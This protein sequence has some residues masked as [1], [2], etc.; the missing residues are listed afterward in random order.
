MK[1]SIDCAPIAIEVTEQELIKASDAGESW[2][3][4]QQKIIEDLQSYAKK[5][6]SHPALTGLKMSKANETLL[7]RILSK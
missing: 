6:K 2:L 4:F 3:L 1:I 5:R 7:M